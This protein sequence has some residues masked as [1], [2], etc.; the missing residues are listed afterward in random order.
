MGREAVRAAVET[1]LNAGI[2]ASAIPFLGKVYAHPPRLTKTSDFVEGQD[3]GIGSG[4]V[5][6]LHLESQHEHRI[7]I[8]PSNYDNNTAAFKMRTY[9][10]GFI[11]VFRSVKPSLNEAGVDCDSF[12]DGLVAWIE[13]DRKCGTG[14]VSPPPDTFPPGDG[15]GVVFQWGEG[16][17]T[18]GA[19]DISIKAGMPKMMKGQSSQTFSTLDVYLL[20]QVN[21]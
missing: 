14:E 12:L 1:Y 13:R 17:E 6:Y 4:A 9:N 15:S 7:T 8:G 21:T 10:V 16:G 3:P 11:C 19:V 2:T 18:V 20:E 5:I